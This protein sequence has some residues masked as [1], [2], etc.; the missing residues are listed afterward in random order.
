MRRVLII[1][2]IALSPALH[3]VQWNPSLGFSVQ[4]AASRIEELERETPLWHAA[5]TGIILSPLSL[6]FG[7]H[8]VSIPMEVAYISDSAISSGRR[9]PGAFSGELSLRYG[10]MFQESAELSLSADAAVL[11]HIKQNALSWRFGASL[12]GTYYPLAYLGIS[13]PLSV[14]WSGGAF[15]FSTGLGIVLKLRGHI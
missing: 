6:A 4:Y 13:L 7:K 14:S 8:T 2:F 3:A 15:H 9:I 11:W 1:L 10:Y 12:S 5:R